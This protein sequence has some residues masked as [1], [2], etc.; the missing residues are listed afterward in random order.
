MD[1]IAKSKVNE[2]AVLISDF[3]LVWDTVEFSEED[4]SL[5]PNTRN[6]LLADAVAEMLVRAGVG[7]R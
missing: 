1:S 3:L 6:T 2:V 4:N 5:V 7:P